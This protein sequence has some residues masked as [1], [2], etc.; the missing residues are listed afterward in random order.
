MQAEPAQEAD[1]VIVGGGSAG[2]V[3]AA[4]LTEDPSVSVV[5][6]EAGDRGAGFWVNMPAGTFRLMGRPASDWLYEV[7]PDPTRLGRRQTWSGGRMLGGSSA[8]NGM[9]YIRGQRRDYDDWAADGCPAG[10][11]TTSC[12]ISCARSGSPGRRRRRTARMGRWRS[13][14]RAPSTR[15]RAPSCG[16]AARSACRCW[17]TIAPATSTAPS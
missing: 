3:L 2:C 6:L 17:T 9:V 16:L 11:S 14:R 12:P 10:A 15:L 8:I 13:R 7:E 1:Y 5:L 4:R